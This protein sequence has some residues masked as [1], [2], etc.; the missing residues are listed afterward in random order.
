MSRKATQVSVSLARIFVS[1][2]T[3]RESW[4]E[5]NSLF[6]G[7]RMIRLHRILDVSG[8]AELPT[9]EVLLIR[10]GP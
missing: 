1:W 4:T 8:K 7:F 5:G 9:F 2:M 3:R 6:A 10:N